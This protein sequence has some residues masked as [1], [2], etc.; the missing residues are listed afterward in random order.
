[1]I[2]KLIKK[3]TTFVVSAAMVFSTITFTM[4]ENS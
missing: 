2:S 1:M 3:T 4:P